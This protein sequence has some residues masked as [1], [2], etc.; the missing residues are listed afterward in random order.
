MVSAFPLESIVLFY[1]HSKFLVSRGVRYLVGPILHS[2][3]VSTTIILSLLHLQYIEQEQMCS[4]RGLYKPGNGMRGSSVRVHRYSFLHSCRAAKLACACAT[5]TPGNC[6]MNCSSSARRNTTR[7]ENFRNGTRCRLTRAL[8]AFSEHPS[9]WLAVAMSR[10][11]PL[12]ALRF[13]SILP[14]VPTARLNFLRSTT[15]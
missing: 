6:S 10:S 7:P 1:F 8:S 11:W 14:V 3:V 2:R 4:S 12:M 13:M 5:V 9:H 15:P